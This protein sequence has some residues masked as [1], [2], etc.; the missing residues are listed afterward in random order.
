MRILVIGGTRFMGPHIIRSLCAAGH[1]VSVFHRG[2]TR[3][4]LPGEV[5]EILGN[6][7]CLPEYA[8]DFRCECARF[9]REVR[10][11]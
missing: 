6:R 4:A 11:Q 2:Q 3:A 8:S 10:A 9:L 5:K 1:E 7:D